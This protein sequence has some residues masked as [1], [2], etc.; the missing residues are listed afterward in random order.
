M[1][2]AGKNKYKMP[3]LRSVALKYQNWW[4]FKPQKY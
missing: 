1:E 4:Q 3:C 2:R